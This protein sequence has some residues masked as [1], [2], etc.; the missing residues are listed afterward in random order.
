M[1][2]DNNLE[3]GAV[4]A[5]QNEE[6]QGIST[7]WLTNHFKL[8]RILQSMLTRLE[9]KFGEDS[10]ESAHVQMIGTLEQGQSWEIYGLQRRG[11]IYYLQRHFQTHLPSL[12]TSVW[13]FLQVLK[14][15]ARVRLLFQALVPKIEA[16]PEK[17]GHSKRRK[18]NPMQ[19]TPAKLKK[20]GQ[21]GQATRRA[22]CGPAGRGQS[23]G[24]K[25]AENNQEDEPQR[26]GKLH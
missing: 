22:R 18:L 6:L 15:A 3:Y 8:A 10:V 25:A 13:K 24:A 20:D 21:G 26:S 1:K 4:E 12:P 9:N 11:A 23:A 14:Q 19:S 7:K 16:L 5:A 17:F 2:F